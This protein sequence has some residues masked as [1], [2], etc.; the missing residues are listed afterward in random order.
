[1]CVCAYV[2]SSWVVLV[3]VGR[4]WMAADRETFC[5]TRLSSY[6]PLS[7]GGGERTHNGT[8]TVIYSLPK[9]LA[10]HMYNTHT[11]P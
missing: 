8:E 10:L 6:V 1:M 2:C 3:V 7:G 4:P 5:C 9:L 11:H